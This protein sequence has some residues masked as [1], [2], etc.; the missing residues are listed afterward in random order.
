M[1]PHIYHLPTNVNIK[2][3]FDFRFVFKR[4]LEENLQLVVT[5][6]NNLNLRDMYRSP[7]ITVTEVRP[8]RHSKPIQN[9]NKMGNVDPKP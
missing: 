8:C 5:K 1:G 6:K 2:R 9:K 3:N 7:T 4:G